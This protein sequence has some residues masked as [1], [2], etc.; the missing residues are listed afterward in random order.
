MLKSKN[1]YLELYN[2]M[3]NLSES[4][5]G[6]SGLN[7][8]TL[9]NYGIG[10]MLLGAGLNLGTNA[11]MSL[12]N[13]ENEIELANKRK[14]TIETNNL[15]NHRL[16]NLYNDDIQYSSLSAYGGFLDF[17]KGGGL[18]RE[19]D[20]G[21][22]KKP[23]PSVSKGDFAGGGR[24]YPIPTKADAI[25]ALRLAGLHGRSDVKV[26]VYEKYPELK[27]ACGGKLKADGGSLT[28]VNLGD[29]LTY[30][31]NGGSHENN[32]LG[33]IPVGNKGLVEEGEFRFN[34][35]IFSNRLK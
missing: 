10:G 5:G 34:D 35:Y 24:S 8:S 13:E 21:S 2:N 16:S 23:Y 30:Y 7:T 12:I 14:D 27:K 28:D 29:N 9:P 31:A 25:D 22:K 20:Y 6:F 17:A 32:P 11:L 15:I 19:E 4:S 3:N 26:K 33:G 18:S 1:K